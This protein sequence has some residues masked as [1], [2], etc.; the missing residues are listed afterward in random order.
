MVL[1]DGD[2]TIF[3]DKLLAKGEA[4]GKDAAAYL[5]SSV[6]QFVHERIPDLATDYKIVTRVYANLKGLGD[7]C[8]RAG[9]VETPAVIND[10]ARGFT[11][12]KQLFDF[13][14]VG[15]G[16]DRAD[17]KISGNTPN[18]PTPIFF[19]EIDDG[20]RNIQIAS[21]RYSLQAH[22]IWLLTRQRLRPL[23]RRY[24]RQSHTELHHPPGRRSLRA[25]TRPAKVPIPD[26]PL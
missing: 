11:G 13:V 25:R 23:A 4:G 14:D 12:S 17:D 16:K 8:Q 10:F 24:R 18:P 5:W 1:I 26:H 20:N 6:S 22:T 19:L 15:V 2:G 21:L 9:L 3:N 7:V